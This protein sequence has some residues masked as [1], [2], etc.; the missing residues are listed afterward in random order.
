[1]TKAEL[2]KIYSDKR[3]GL[4]Q[5]ECASF[6]LQLYHFFFLHID[7]S[8]IKNLHVYLPMEKNNEPDTW[9]IIDRVRS[10]FP[11][12]RI[13]IPKVNNQTAELENFYFEGPHQLETNSWGVPEPKQGIPTPIEKI[14]LALVPL[15]CFDWKGDRIG[16]GKGFYDRFFSKCKPDCKKVGLSFFEPVDSIADVNEHDVKLTSCITPKQVYHF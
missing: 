5:S 11:N 6:N 15:L 2:R 7:L 10:E 13:C 3:K 9:A 1:M 8:F 16:Y 12:V 14:D 4:S